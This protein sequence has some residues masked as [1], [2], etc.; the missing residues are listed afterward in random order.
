MVDGDQLMTETVKAAELVCELS[1]RGVRFL[2]EL[3]QY[4]SEIGYLKD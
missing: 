2:R 3:V 4:R 1:L